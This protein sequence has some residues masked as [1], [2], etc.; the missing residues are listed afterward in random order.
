MRLTLLLLMAIPFGQ[1][2]PADPAKPVPKVEPQPRRYAA[3]LHLR[4]DGDKI[5]KAG[6]NPFDVAQSLNMFLARHPRFKL[7]ELQAVKVGDVPLRELLVIDV[8]FE[9]PA[10]RGN[11]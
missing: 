6:L 9:G 1:D 2:R 7:S 10:A 3:A 11:K 5:R 4:M 8:E